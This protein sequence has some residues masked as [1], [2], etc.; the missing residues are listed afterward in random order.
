MIHTRDMTRN[1]LIEYTVIHEKDKNIK[2]RKSMRQWY[3]LKHVRPA[4]MLDHGS[5]RKHGQHFNERSQ[6]NYDRA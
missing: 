6:R 1:L 3:G 2:A 4:K 5:G